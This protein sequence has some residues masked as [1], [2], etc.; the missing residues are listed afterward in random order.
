MWKSIWHTK[1]FIQNGVKWNV[2][3]GT[4]INF[5][6]DWWCGDGPLINCIN[7]LNTTF[8]VNDVLIRNLNPF[9]NGMGVLDESS[10]KNIGSTHIAKNGVLLDHPHWAQN[11]KGKFSIKSMYEMIR[12]TNKVPALT[13]VNGLGFGS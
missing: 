6:K 10:I 13:P 12:N 1:P 7:G 8:S 11:S 4:C 9:E 3:D 2:G 5:A